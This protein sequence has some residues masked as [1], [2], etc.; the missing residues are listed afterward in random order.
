MSRFHTNPNTGN[1]GPCSATKGGCPFGEDADH[2]STVEDA[3]AAYEAKMAGGFATVEDR[4]DASFG[5]QVPNPRAPKG[6]PMNTYNVSVGDEFI[7]EDGYSYLVTGV[8]KPGTFGISHSAGPGVKLTR[9]KDDGSFSGYSRTV[10]HGGYYKPEN[11]HSPVEAQSSEA[12]VPEPFQVSETRKNVTDVLHV[13]LDLRGNSESYT[14]TSREL[15]RDLAEREGMIVDFSEVMKQKTTGEESLAWERS[16]YAAA[17][18]QASHERV[19]LQS[20]PREDRGDREA[21]RAK[22]REAEAKEAFAREDYMA[23][24]V[25]YG[26]GPAEELEIA[27]EIHEASRAHQAVRYPGEDLGNLELG[28]D[29]TPEEYK[30]ARLA[31]ARSALYSFEAMDGNRTLA[32]A[33]D[34][35]RWEQRYPDSVNGRTFFSELP[36]DAQKIHTD[37]AAM[38]ARLFDKD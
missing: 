21:Y 23:R 17:Y 32:A 20:T 7:D 13:L 34:H 2:Y 8:V 11:Y 24:R 29:E 12:E 1:S 30:Q 15:H 5:S 14:G 25:D 26:Y 18:R 37:R 3:R 4:V 10:Q 35:H 6:A 36:E 9:L 22:M 28:F 31:D 19:A 38:V 27:R 16:E 33:F